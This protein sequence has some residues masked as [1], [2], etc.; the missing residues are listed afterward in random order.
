MQRRERRSP[1]RRAAD[2]LLLAA[3]G[4]GW[5][6]LDDV[7]S[8]MTPWVLPGVAHRRA[9]RARK[10]ES[11]PRHQDAKTVGA[12]KVV[13]ETVHMALRHKWEISECGTKV[14]HRDWVS[15]DAFVIP[16]LGELEG[17]SRLLLASDWERSA[18]VA[19][20]VEEAEFGS[21]QH[22]GASSSTLSPQRFAALGIAGLK[23]KDTVRR[24]LRAWTSTVG[25]R[26]TPGEVTELP[27]IPF[28]TTRE[29]DGEAPPVAD[30]TSLP[31]PKPK[32]LRISIESPGKAV[33]EAIAA[34]GG[35]GEARDFFRAAL[36]E[37]DRR[38]V[39]S[40]TD[41]RKNR[42]RKVTRNGGEVIQLRREA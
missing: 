35:Y 7:K 5:V 18:I 29:R 39:Q 22:Q 17:M 32:A 14:R 21:N 30:P 4:D 42:N 15:S 27:R 16:T 34:L 41:K 31:K 26:P 38:L 25:A 37:S 36:E 9:A 3:S 40:Q 10:T 24:Y 28:P 13:V 20:F 2:D 12:R 1:Q 19:A 6:S 8:H 23:S 33:S 11:D